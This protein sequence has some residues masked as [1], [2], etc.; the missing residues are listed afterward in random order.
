MMRPPGEGRATEASRVLYELRTYTIRS[1]LLPD[2]LKI[3]GEV[4]MPIRGDNYGKLVGAW[5]TEIGPLNQYLHLWAYDD[6]NERLRL[7]NE[8]NSKPE[9]INDYIARTQPMV[10]SQE[11]LILNLD[12]ELGLHPVEGGGHVY[13]LRQYVAGVGELAGWA[14]AFK[15]ALVARRNYSEIVGLWTSEV[16]MLNQVAHLWVY[17][18]LNQRATARAAAAKDPVWSGFVEVWPK[19][20]TSLK[21]AILLPTPFSPLQ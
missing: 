18:D 14:K 7:R 9:W 1:G 5:F 6:A 4:G 17:D 11:N 15:Q 12:E 16:G 13:E 10:Q 8:L 3:V 20:L 2:F 21:T 19:V